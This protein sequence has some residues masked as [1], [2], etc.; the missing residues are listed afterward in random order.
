MDYYCTGC[1]I[2][3]KLSC[4]E[5]PSKDSLPTDCPYSEEINEERGDV[6]SWGRALKSI[7]P[8]NKSLV[9]S[10]EDAQNILRVYIKEVHN[11]CYSQE[12]QY[13]RVWDVMRTQA[14]QKD[15]EL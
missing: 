6:V 1:A 9:I 8:V 14:K 11:A 5:E 13:N 3:C 4:D 12:E 10:L 15:M 2:N 7:E